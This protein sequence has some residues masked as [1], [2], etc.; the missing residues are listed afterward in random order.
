MRVSLYPQQL[1]D[2]LILLL[3]LLLLLLNLLQLLLNLLLL[4]LNLLLLLLILLMQLQ[5][6]L[7]HHGVNHACGVSL[8]RCRKRRERRR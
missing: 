1:S 8:S 6:L 7:L 5:H 2:R 3:N 4:L